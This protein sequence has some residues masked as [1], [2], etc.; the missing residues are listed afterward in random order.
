MRKADVA[1]FSKLHEHLAELCQTVKQ[2]ETNFLYCPAPGKLH[3][4]IEKLNETNVP[5]NIISESQ[6][7]IE[8]SQ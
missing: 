1:N 7:H 4:V 2:S 3:L 8:Q 6:L 5:F